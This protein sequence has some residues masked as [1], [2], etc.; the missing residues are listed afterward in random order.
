[1]TI[2]PCD[3][4]FDTMQKFWEAHRISIIDF[5]QID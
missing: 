3:V 5:G 2:P 4:S 1:V